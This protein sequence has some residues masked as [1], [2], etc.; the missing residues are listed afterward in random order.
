[1]NSRRTKGSIGAVVISLVLLGSAACTG[2]GGDGAGASTGNGGAA[3]S[4][5][6]GT[7]TVA[8]SAQAPSLDPTNNLAESSMEIELHVFDSLVTY[9][10]NFKIMPDLAKSWKVSKDKKTYTFSL[11]SGIRFQNGTTMT[12]KDVVASLK[13][14]RRMGESS[15]TLKKNIRS[16]STS[17]SDKVVVKL[18]HRYAILAV[19]GNPLPLIPIMPAKYAKINKTLKPPRLIGTGP[20]K[21]AAWKPDQYT[22]LREFKGYTPANDGQATGLGGDR[23]AK[24]SEIKWVPVKQAQTRLSGLKRGEFDYA[25]GL[26]LTSYKS[27]KADSQ[28]RPYV[29]KDSSNLAFWLNQSSGQALSNKYLRQAIVAALNDTSILNAAASGQSKFYDAQGSIFWPSQ[30]LWYDADA[31]KGIYNSP[32]KTRVKSLLAKANYDGKPLTIVTNHAYPYMYSEAVETQ[33]ELKAAGIHAK[34]K[35]IDWSAGTS[36][37]TQKSGWDMFASSAIFQVDPIGWYV[38]IAPNASLAPGFTSK[39]MGTLLNRG[40]S[41]SSVP[42]RQKI[43][44]KVQQRVWEDVPTLIIGKLDSLHASGAQMKGYRPYF[45]PRF[46]NVAG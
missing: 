37:L 13:R 9:D 7:L 20:Y 14:A 36:L 15:D 46:W 34:L 33:R 28:L 21:I 8:A 39:K 12:A 44:Q 3:G 30:K 11:A 40:A 5:G 27:V 2:S 26:P 29:I 38:I 1:M 43:Y 32:N 24:Y 16:I 23:V 19:L 4:G 18:A 6:T 41:S 31:G 17:G 42:A 35:V 25:E 10:E 22:L 45:T